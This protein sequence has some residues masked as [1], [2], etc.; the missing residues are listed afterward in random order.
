MLMAV[1]GVLI[2]TLMSSSLMTDLLG[3]HSSFF[4]SMKRYFE[5]TYQFGHYSATKNQDYSGGMHDTYSISPSESRFWT[6]K[7]KDQ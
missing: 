5:S 2:T 1:V 6:S 7:E 3:P 4:D